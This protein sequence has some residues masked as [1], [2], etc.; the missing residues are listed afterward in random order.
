MEIIKKISEVKKKILEIK[1]SKKTIGF[2]PTMGALH[3][4]HLQLVKQSVAENDFTIVSV[5]VNPIQFNNAE[6][7]K[8]YPR[9][10][11][12]DV[13]LLE[14]A[15]CNFVFTPEVEEMYPEPDNT[16]FDF[17]K[18]DKV[19][20]GA[21]R[22]GHFRGVA[23]V[24]KKLF[25]ITKPNR[26]YFGKKDY[27]QLAIIK[28]LVEDYKM[29]LEIIPCETVREKDGLAMSSR[30]LR[31]TK[32][33]REVAPKIYKALKNAKKIY[34]KHTP[35]ELEK[36]IK[37]E[38]ENEKMISVEYVSI[39]DSKT[40]QSIDKW[41]DCK[42]CVVCLACFLGKVRLIDNIEIY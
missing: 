36:I 4:G 21:A 27:Q 17:G 15:G 10:L 19:M 32:E 2:V 8:K 28:Q 34:K 42:H 22:P 41:E 29:P 16:E 5:F 31:L 37:T 20:E 23:V 7:L 35:K 12:K 3:D 30:N 25:E 11:D 13:K 38:I 24:V 9:N 40:L 33:E 26:A 39:V 6:D 1:K 18:L 14:E